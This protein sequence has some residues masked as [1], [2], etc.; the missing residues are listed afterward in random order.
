MHAEAPFIYNL[1]GT[2]LTLFSAHAFCTS[3]KAGFKRHARTWVD[4]EA[5]N[6]AGIPE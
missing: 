2:V 4:S 3:H 1:F 6:C 5:I